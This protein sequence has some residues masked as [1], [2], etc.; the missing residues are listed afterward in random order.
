MK[1]TFFLLF[2]ILIS[3]SIY[4]QETSEVSNHFSLG[5]QIGQ[6][7]DD[8]G[9]GLAATS[10]YFLKNSVA[11]RARGNFM[12]F[13]HVM[14]EETTW[15]PYTN[16]QLGLVGVGGMVGNM[17]LYGEGGGI[18][19]FPNADFSNNVEFGGYGLFGFEFYMWERMNYH[20]EIGGVGSGARAE[21]K[22]N[23]PI[24]SNGLS[25]SAGFRVHF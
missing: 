21:L 2:S 15:S 14:N 16:V 3:S 18:V 12:F 8:F 10:P 4:A 7:Q 24:Y 25:I 1:N 6:Y 23:K 5:Y 9:F 22:D 20:I 19:I 11:I 13:E 17:R